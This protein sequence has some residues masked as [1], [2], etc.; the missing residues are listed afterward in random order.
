[1]L[2]NMQCTEGVCVECGATES[3][4]HPEVDGPAWCAAC[5]WAFGAASWVCNMEFVAVAP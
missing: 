3:L 1:M 2:R 4:P 5:W